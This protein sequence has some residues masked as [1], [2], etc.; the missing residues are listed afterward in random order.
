MAVPGD[1]RKEPPVRGS[2]GSMGQSMNFTGKVNGSGGRTPP[3]AKLSVKKG[4]QGQSDDDFF[5]MRRHEGVRRCGIPPVAGVSVVC[6]KGAP[7]G[8]P[9]LEIRFGVRRARREARFGPRRARPAAVGGS[10]ALGACAVGMSH[11]PLTEGSVRRGGRARF[12][13]NAGMRERD[14]R[15]EGRAKRFPRSG[16]IRSPLV[17]SHA[18]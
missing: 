10:L 18:G 11:G 17:F 15:R 12:G 8:P 4:E 3:H 1:E 14:A 2:G 13:K 7:D 5:S 6:G 16:N 9:R